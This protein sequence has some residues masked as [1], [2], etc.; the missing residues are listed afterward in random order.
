[1]TEAGYTCCSA[2]GTIATRELD[3]NHTSFLQSHRR[4]PATTYTRTSRFSKK[5]VAALLR[6]TTYVPNP[7]IILYL[8]SCRERNLIKSPENLLDA[9]ANYKT[10]ARRP[11]MHATSLWGAMAT[12]PKIPA[13]SL[14]EECFIIAMFEEIFYVWTRLELGRPRLP[15]GQAI[16]LIVTTFGL[17]PQAHFI[18]RFI[19]KLKCDKR[20][21]RYHRLFHKC[22]GH[23]ANDDKRRSRFEIFDYWRNYANSYQE[24][25]DAT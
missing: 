21:A 1:V 12:T 4:L 18:I 24:L 8:D 3:V 6:Q 19:R 7:N 9:I 16:I 11:Y 2:C 5:I 15:M 22:L 17:S 23:I 10:P 20:R 13:I 14:R 25:A